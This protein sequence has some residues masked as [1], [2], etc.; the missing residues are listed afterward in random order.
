[1]A[2]DVKSTTADDYPGVGSRTQSDDG[3]F[4]D[5]KATII[6]V[7]EPETGG[8]LALRRAPARRCGRARE[9]RR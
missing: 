9:R 7:P 3:H 8:L 2:G 4:V 6:S 1:M 5:V